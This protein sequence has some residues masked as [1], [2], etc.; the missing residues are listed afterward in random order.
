MRRFGIN[1]FEVVKHVIP[2]FLQKSGIVNV[3]VSPDG[4]VWIDIYG[5]SWGTQS[6]D[7]HLGWI[8]SFLSPLQ[9]LIN[10]FRD[11]AV[12]TFYK[13]HIT[14]QVVYLEHY[15]N[16]QLDNTLRR[17]YIGDGDLVLPPYLYMKVDG[18]PITL[19]NKSDAEDEFYLYDK[20]DYLVG[21]TTFI[22][23]VPASLPITPELEAIIKSL[24]EPYRMAGALYTIVNY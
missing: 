10:T 8:K 19:Y 21:Q 12:E 3:W 13:L 4:Q 18:K 7:K 20:D 9:T 15:L 5:Q 23:Y 11:F 22:I 16:D 17:I 2:H 1:I 6:S 14:G 24:V